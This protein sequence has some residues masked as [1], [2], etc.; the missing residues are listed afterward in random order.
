MPE[1]K[2]KIFTDFDGTI[3]KRD[4]GNLIFKTFSGDAIYEIIQSWKRNEINS[5]ELLTREAKLAKIKKLD[6]LYELVRAQAID[7]HFLDFVK[8]CKDNDIEIFILS[9]GM[10]FYI[11]MILEKYGISDLPFFSN[12]FT[13]TEND[14]GV[15]IMPVFPFSDSECKSCGNCKRNHLLY[16]KQDDE[17]S[18]YIGDG[19]S[20]RCPVEYAD[21]VF[22]KGELL[23]YCTAKKI[24]FNE[25]RSFSEVN[26]KLNELLLRKRFNP[27]RRAELKRKEVLLQ[28]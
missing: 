25:F 24:P 9:D 27:K 12:R 14:D 3:T 6:D 20:D 5:A 21:I 15:S 18:I 1:V 19:Y 11:K 2:Y 26:D 7:D 13:Y 22:C 8:I 17:I 16:H 4:V 10:D 23:S 28:G